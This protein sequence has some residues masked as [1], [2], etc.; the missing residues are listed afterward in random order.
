MCV[1]LNCGFMLQFFLFESVGLSGI[2]KKLKVGKKLENP[3]KSNKDMRKEEFRKN[4]KIPPKLTNKEENSANQ[5]RN[6]TS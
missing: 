4:N 6:A 5:I 2:R 1:M 3:W